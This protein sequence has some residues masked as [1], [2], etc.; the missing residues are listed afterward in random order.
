V[1][2]PTL[3]I[4][5]TNSKQG[6]PITV[7]GANWPLDAIVIKF[8]TK[9]ARPD[10]VLGGSLW[11]GDVV[12]D[13]K[14]SFVL[15]FATQALKP[16]TYT[17]S[18]EDR[19]KTVQAKTKF[20][21]TARPAGK[22]L[23]RA[24]IDKPYLRSIAFH[25]P[26]TG[27]KIAWPPGLD[28]LW[29]D[30]RIFYK[31][32]VRGG[33]N[34]VPLGPAP[35]SGGFFN[36]D[37]NAG[38]MRCLAIDPGEPNIMYAGAASGG[39]WK[40]TNGGMTW[41]PK[42]DDRLSLAIGAIA[43]DPVNTE[44]IY[45]GTGEYVPGLAGNYYYGRGLLKSIDRGEHWLETSATD[46]TDFHFSEV[47]RIVIDPLNTSNLFVAGSYYLRVSED[48]GQTWATISSFPCSDVTLIRNPA[49]PGMRVLLIGM[50]GIGIRRITNSG[51]GWETTTLPFE[52]PVEGSPPDEPK[53]IVFGVCRTQP[54]VIYAAYADSNNRVAFVA[55]SDDWGQ[56]FTHREM[57]QTTATWNGNYN[58]VIQPHPSSPDTVLFGFVEIHRSTNG[59]QTWESLSRGGGLRPH[60]DHHAIA[61]HPSVNDSLFIA[62]DG[63]IYFSPDVGSTWQARNMDLAT[64][65]LYD[66]GQHPS[67]DAIMLAG[68]QDNNGFVST[69]TPI[70]TQQRS[71][72][73]PRGDVLGTGDIVVAQIDPHDP[74]YQYRTH[75]ID[76]SVSRSDDGGSS[77]SHIW[78]PFPDS[79]WWLPFYADPRTPGVLIGGGRQVH[80]SSN[81][82]DSWEAI[83]GNL[84][85]SLRSIGFHPVD[86]SILY[87]GTT[88]GQI[89]RL[90]GPLSG[91][92]DANSVQTEDVT[93]TGLPAEVG[94][95]SLAVDSSGSVWAT[96]SHISDDEGSGELTN[97]HVFT[98]DE[99]AQTWLMKS[100]GLELANPINTIVIDS[101]D[102]SRMFCG[103]DHGVF[104]WDAALQQWN[105]MDEGLPNSPV[106]KLMIH[107]PSRK[108][109]A[110]TYGR[111]VW[112]RPLAP[113]GCKDHFLYVR[114]TI[115]DSG[116]TPSPDGVPHPF[117]RGELVHR[118]QSPDIIVDSDNQTPALV[119]SPLDLYRFVQHTGGR[120]GANRVYVTVHNKGPFAVTDVR[121]R[122]FLGQASLGLPPFAPGMLDNPL[123]WNPV[124]NIDSFW[125][126]V[127]LTPFPIPRM[128]PGTTRLAGWEF[129]IPMVAA[130]HSCLMAFVSSAEDPFDANGITDPDQLVVHNEKVALKN[131]DLGPIPPVGSRQ[132][133]PWP[134]FM[135]GKLANAQYELAIQCGNVPADAVLLVAL[136]KG[137]KK[138][139]APAK[140]ADTKELR[141]IA[142]EFMKS[143]KHPGEIGAFDLENIL[144][145][146]AK[147]G[148]RLSIG[149]ATIAKGKPLCAMVWMYSL[150]WKSSEKYRFDLLQVL[151]DKVIGGFTV[152]L[153]EP[154]KPKPSR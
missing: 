45:A 8:D 42:S 49:N 97:H 143:G 95:S 100:D 125:Q 138:T 144:V 106:I 93:Y 59:G 113:L 58:L 77:F 94:I 89:Y 87:A 2:K 119:T 108:L 79:E 85:S 109:R 3:Q 137:W 47:A 56:T 78:D 19:S 82:G 96:T 90:S 14:G 114:D 43:I 81:R 50:V 28:T 63:G 112:E 70:W 117:V 120:R 53:R 27:N 110:V 152:Q 121:V 128:E 153:A 62:T 123:T 31:A 41:M 129:T 17:L 134:F 23:P 20:E 33:C 64:L 9:I 118:W 1:N 116:N 91:P 83:S 38:R 146:P 99:A 130:P 104:S 25:R 34:W 145:R 136:E 140:A 111:G 29:S 131:L 15:V 75:Y 7:A 40:S 67:Y 48:S 80:R 44:V 37:N 54:N 30:R 55:R 149:Y 6:E 122:A 107:E 150:K 73:A 103:G 72:V 139:F 76:G 71:T 132:T 4:L 66:A 16:G 32:P 21:I 52:V 10:R 26:R 57:P 84:A 60:F 24:Q 115:V 68:S 5:L 74:Y 147:R 141:K 102:S 127:S 133:E 65:Q 148:E 61:F 35:V 92:W 88:G 135:H 98:L 126:P 101:Q 18:A 105:D 22:N 51:S 36:P 86:P 69:G 151:K 142:A 13:V 39:L 11:K 124:Q 46:A 12:P 154:G